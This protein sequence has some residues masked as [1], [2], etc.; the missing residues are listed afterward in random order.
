MQERVDEAG[1]EDVAGA[2]GVADGDGEGLDV[3]HLAAVPGEHAL[4]AEGGRGEAM[5]V[6]AH[7]GL[8]RG[9]KRGFAGEPLG[10]IAA[11]DGV[12]GERE[13]VVDAGIEFVEIGDGGHMSGARP[14]GRVGGGGGVI[15]IDE[16]DAGLLNPVGAQLGGVEILAGIATPEDGALAVRIEEDDALAAV[17]VGDGEA[18]GVDAEAGELGRMETGR[19]VVT[20][21]ADVARGQAP[22]GAGGDGGGNLSAGQGE[23]IAELDLAAGERKTGQDDEGVGGVEAEADDIDERRGMRSGDGICWRGMAQGISV[24]HRRV[25]FQDRAKRGFPIRRATLIPFL[26]FPSHLA[27]LRIEWNQHDWEKF[28]IRQTFSCD[29]C[30]ADKK[31]SN[32][33]FVALERDGEIRLGTWAALGRRR[34][35]ALH[36]CGQKCLYKLVD[37]FFVRRLVGVRPPVEAEQPATRAAFAA[38]PEFAAESEF[39][40]MESSARLIPTPRV[41]RDAVPEAAATTAP[42]LPVRAAGSVAGSVAGSGR[43]AARLSAVA[44]RT[45]AGPAVLKRKA[46]VGDMAGARPRMAAENLPRLAGVEMGETKMG[47]T[48]MGAEKMAAQAMAAE[49]MPAPKIAGPALAAQRQQEAA[50]DRHRASDA[51]LRERAREQTGGAARATG[52][53]RRSEPRGDGRAAA[54]PDSGSRLVPSRIESRLHPILR[55]RALEA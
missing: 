16:E 41:N 37:D 21:L 14:V 54:R 33:W 48:R 35:G 12:V 36:L 4:F 45:A 24:K 9:G 38:E 46:N 26:F 53:L 3:Q 42:S 20:E 30:G 6:A 32:H 1:V 27:S 50:A 55:P 5:A 8:E 7:H 52:Q 40:E 49:K 25:L 19:G 23:Q 22:G 51:W 28:V 43:R 17:A 29:I 31:E 15:A 39:A 10:K 11:D 13:Q 34:R 44:A 47:E 18:V 2:G